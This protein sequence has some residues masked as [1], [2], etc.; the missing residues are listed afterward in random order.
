MIY[1]WDRS[2][3][4]TGQVT[5]FNGLETGAW[6]G[7]F[8]Q[9]LAAFNKISHLDMKM[10]EGKSKGSA[11]IVMELSD[12]KGLGFSGTMLHGKTRMYRDGD[13]GAIMNV[14]CFLPATPR[15][16]HPNYLLFIAVHELV[17][18]MGLDNDE[19]AS[20]GVFITL[21]NMQEGKIFSTKGSKK[22][23]P[24]FLNA[25]TRSKLQAAW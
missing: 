2:V 24:L 21:P 7:I 11:N 17:H 23:P 20:D 16:N 25:S 4:K 1:K 6:S 8:A 9:A 18:A 13:S 10:V 15:H 5:V 3:R 19:H 12:G 22:M 14:E